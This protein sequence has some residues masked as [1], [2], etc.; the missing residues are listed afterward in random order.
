VPPVDIAAGRHTG[1]PERVAVAGATLLAFSIP[2]SVALDNMLLA[3]IWVFFWLIRPLRQQIPLVLKNPVAGAAWL[4]FGLLVLGLLHGERHDGD[5]LRY[6]T[7]YLDFLFVPLFIVLFR[8]PQDRSTG[9]RCFC[10]AMIVTFVVARLNA[11][12]L[13]QDHPV[14]PRYPEYPGAFKFSITHGVLSTFAGFA[15]ALLAREARL[16]SSRLLFIVLML[17]AIQNAV[18]VA[19]SRTGYVLLSVLAVYFLAV[20]LPRRYLR[21]AV[22]GIAALFALAYTA[23]PTL[24]LRV[25]DAVAEAVE[26]RPGQA[27]GTSVGLRL[28]FYRTSMDIVRERPFGAGTGSFPAAYG[29]AVAGTTRV[30]STNPHNDYL[31]IAVQIGLP[32]LALLLYYFWQQWRLAPMLPTRLERDLARGLVLTFA[33]GG[34]FNSFLLDHT[35]GLLFAWLTGLLYAGLQSRSP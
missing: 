25:V 29:K 35:E 10:I 31:L 16:W 1:T 23:S 34:M 3:L 12:G 21:V 18:F 6:L 26:W 33:I 2:V 19:I 7:R 13:L 28:E 24:Q 17:T 27:S 8:N 14:L 20:T 9:L 5:G 11:L 15:F 4:L 22:L 32:G 30:A